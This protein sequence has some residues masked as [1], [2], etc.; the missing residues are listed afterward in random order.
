VAVYVGGKKIHYIASHRGRRI[1]IG[2]TDGVMGWEGN[3]GWSE[4]RRCYDFM[5]Y[6]VMENKKVYSCERK[7]EVILVC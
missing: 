1:W 3:M 5:I 4:M 2:L 6:D 7:F